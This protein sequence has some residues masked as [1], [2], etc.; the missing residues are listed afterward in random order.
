MQERSETKA[1]L[2]GKE[3]VVILIRQD[4]G[5]IIVFIHVITTW[6]HYCLGLYW[7][8]MGL[9]FYQYILKLLMFSTRTP[10][11]G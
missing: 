11:P 3:A 7:S 6:P 8:L 1:S 9:I 2:V 10:Q 5:R 4:I